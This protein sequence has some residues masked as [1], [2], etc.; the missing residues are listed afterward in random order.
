MTKGKYVGHTATITRLSAASARLT[1][2]D[3]RVTG[4]VKL[5]SLT[6]ARHAT[7]VAAERAVPPSPGKSLLLRGLGARHRPPPSP[8]AMPTARSRGV[9]A[10]S[11]NPALRKRNR[12]AAAKGSLI[13]SIA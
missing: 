12:P 2:A 5:S 4:N 11:G 1:L 10:V 8:A 13:P 9:G 3:G 6:S 7:K